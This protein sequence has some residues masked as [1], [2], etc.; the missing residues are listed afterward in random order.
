MRKFER[1][2]YR[3]FK[4]DVYNAYG[5]AE[6][7]ETGEKLVVYQRLNDARWFVRPVEMFL[8]KVDKEKYPEAKQEYRF[9]K[10]KDNEWL[11]I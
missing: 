6:H 2:L 7:S 1:G 9:E 11:I 3:H 5:I 8:S 4:G 10:V